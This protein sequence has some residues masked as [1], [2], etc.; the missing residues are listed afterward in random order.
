MTMTMAV[1]IQGFALCVSIRGLSLH[2]RVVAIPT[3]AV[4]KGKVAKGKVAKPANKDMDVKG[5]VRKMNTKAMHATV[6]AM[7]H[8]KNQWACLCP[9]VRRRRRN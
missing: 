5:N 6:H 3:L 9:M 8:V 4:G 7:Q 1:S 2:L